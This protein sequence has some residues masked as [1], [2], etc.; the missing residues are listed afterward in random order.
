MKRHLSTVTA[1]AIAVAGIAGYA[2][3]RDYRYT[4]ID[5]P[6][7]TYTY[8]EEI[9]DFGQIVG[10]YTGGDGVWHGF[11]LSGGVYTSFD[12]PDATGDGT[13]VYGVNSVGQIVGCYKHADGTW[14]GFLR[15]GVNYSELVRYEGSPDTTAVAIN[16]VGQVVGYFLDDDYVIHGFLFDGTNYTTLDDTN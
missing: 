7:A 10:S 9:N 2:R 1:V 5:Y 16:D 11:T 12:H 15:D 14:R 3:A 4:T 13:A 6:G 8:A